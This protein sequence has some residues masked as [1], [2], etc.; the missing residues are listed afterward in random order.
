MTG[1]PK[2][3][4]AME[5]RRALNQGRFILVSA[6]VLS[7][8]YNLLRLTGPLFMLL[9]YDRVLT[10]RS[11]ET[12]VTLFILMATFLVV[13]GLFDYARRRILA[14]FAAQFQERVEDQIFRMTPRDRFFTRAHS[15]PATG[16][17]ELD[18][19][20]GF[21][22]SRALI[23]FLDFIWAPMFLAVVF[24]LHW[25]L[26]LV[27]VGG[28]CVLLLIVGIKH[29]FAQKR[30]EQSRAAT[31]RITL[32]KDMM[33]ASQSLIRA[34]EM[35]GAF[36]NRWLEARRNSRD[37]AIEQKDWST[38]F[39][40][41]SR[42]TRMLL[43][44]TV[45]AVGAYL[46]IQGQLTVGAM[47]ACTFL[48]VRVIVPVEDFLHEIPNF[49]TALA[50]WRRLRAILGGYSTLPSGEDPDSLPI[51]LTLKQVSVRAPLTNTPV[52]RS[53]SLDL[54]AGDVVQIVGATGAGKTV[55]A[56]TLQ[57][58]C[59][60][61][62][63]ELLYGEAHMD[64]FAVSDTAHIFGYVAEDTEFL[65]ATIEENIARLSPS[66]DRALVTEV[67]R[68]VGLHAMIMALP[69]GYETELDT[70]HPMFSSGQRMQLA[71]ARALYGEP[72]VL[73]IDG[74]DPMM[75]RALLK[76]LR[77]LI[78]RFQTE[79]RIVVLLVRQPLALPCITRHFTL[80]AGR[81]KPSE[82]PPAVTDSKPSNVA[83]LA[84][85]AGSKAAAKNVTKLVRG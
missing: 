70:A 5:A 54:R 79:G 15:K 12:L 11:S 80:E 78:E 29:L 18:M 31:H 30:A 39:V 16:L 47:V 51:R 84:P 32:L 22:H 64:R 33:T 9:I 59:P 34:Q 26:G 46:T 77:P 20:R 21:F 85:A 61:N 23:S 82:P 1:T 37:R 76:P 41:L 58:L 25:V 81:L 8:L 14:R 63:G 38:W 55:L 27:A 6:F 75:R 50:N 74:P 65:T 49:T 53:L 73:I 40:I 44:Y 10:S 72:R 3:T 4:A 19:L 36:R 2:Q 66:P 60:R 69:K 67:A 13:M 57:G 83:K 35:A 45:L 56:E 71:L 42:Q 52:L 24:V 28:L 68:T 43:Q 7:F 62:A 48:V 17:D